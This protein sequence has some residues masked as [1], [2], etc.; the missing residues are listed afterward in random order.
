MVLEERQCLVANETRERTALQRA[1]A[2]CDRLDCREKP[3]GEI[4]RA[5]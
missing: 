3:G 5:A 4:P 1:I 2:G